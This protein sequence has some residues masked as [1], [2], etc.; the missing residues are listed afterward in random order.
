[1]TVEDLCKCDAC[2]DT[3]D[4]TDLDD[5][6]VC[7]ECREEIRHERQLRLDYYSRLL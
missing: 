7:V 5:E 2:G 4:R 3:V 6:G 1:M